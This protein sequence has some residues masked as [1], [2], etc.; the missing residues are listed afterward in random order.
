MQNFD[1]DLFVIGAGSGGVRAARIAAGYGA[2]GRRSP[3]SSASAAPA[4]SAAACRKSSM[5]YASRF[6]DEF[7]DAAG[8]GWSVPAPRFD[9]PKLVAA[10]EKEI[11]RLSGIYRA[12]LDKAGVAHHREPRR[13][14]RARTR[15]RLRPTAARSSRA[16]HTRRD[17]RQR[18]CW[19]RRFPAANTPSPRTKCSI[20]RKLPKRLLIV[21]GGYIAV[22]FA[23]DFRAARRQGDARDARRERAARLRRRHARRR[24]ATR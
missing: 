5:V 9:W 6:A 13:N 11:S 24:R 12:N 4:S 19:S 16:H 1:V 17:R 3:R 2:Q 14:P 8:F 20:C 10:K 22:E 15:V 18:R 7:D 23:C 21:G